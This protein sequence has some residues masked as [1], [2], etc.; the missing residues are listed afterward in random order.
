MNKSKYSLIILAGV[1]FALSAKAQ[2]VNTSTPNIQTYNTATSSTVIITSPNGYKSEVVSNYD[3]D[4]FHT[5]ATSTPLTAQDIQ[6]IRTN[7]QTEEADI[8]QLFQQQEALFKE[9]EQMFQNM[10]NN[11]NW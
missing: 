5:F 8:Q 1:L 2:L 7:I 4:Q 9:Q 11:V 3:G 10:F 6:N